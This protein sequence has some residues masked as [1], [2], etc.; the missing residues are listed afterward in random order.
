MAPRFRPPLTPPEIRA[1]RVR[2]AFLTCFA[3]F[4]VAML[5]A[6]AWFGL[7]AQ[8]RNPDYALSPE[9]A[10][11]GRLV[12]PI[13]PLLQEVCRRS[14]GAIRP[15]QEAFFASA[16]AGTGEIL[17]WRDDSSPHWLMFLPLA[18]PHRIY[19]KHLG[20]VLGAV[21]T[22][23][24]RGAPGTA[25]TLAYYELRREGV[26]LAPMAEFPSFKI[27]RAD[28]PHDLGLL[29]R[30]PQGFVPPAWR[31]FLPAELTD[32]R[33]DASLALRWGTAAA[34]DTSAT[35]VLTVASPRGTT[36]HQVA[37]LHPFWHPREGTHP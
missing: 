6:T 22:L 18:K 27:V 21:S 17:Y 23:A 13:K 10:A 11:D 7:V 2:A 29:Y 1:R 24:R 12:F 26:L 35:V 19:R 20:E 16:F 4:C 15:D 14:P 33:A 32:V 25:E 28:P 5:L 36:D 9:V 3:L 34:S 37:W 31:R 8:R 30:A